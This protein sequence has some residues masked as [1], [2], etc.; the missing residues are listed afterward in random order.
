MKSL[1]NKKTNKKLAALTLASLL[2]FSLTACGEEGSKPGEPQKTVTE[3]GVQIIKVAHT[4]YYIPYDFADEN[5][6]SDGYEVAVLRAVD[7]LLPQY[8]FEFYPTTDD[9]LLIGVETG[10]YDVGTKGVWWTQARSETYV[11]PKQYIGASVIGI[12]TRS[13]DKDKYSSLEAFAASG[14]KLVPIAPQNA[15]YNIIQNFNA[16]HPD[17]Q[18]NLVEA[19][20]FTQSDA[21]QWLREGRYD[22]YVTIKTSFEASVLKE[23]GEYHDF[24]SELS[25]VDYEGIPTWPLFNINNQ[26]LADAYDEAIAQLIAD[27]TIEKI[28]NEY[29]GY[30]LFDYV[31]EGYKIGDDL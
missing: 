3:D 1:F 12:A 24:A 7:E 8:Q 10:K 29:F 5:G 18:I 16:K 22:A 25:Y 2:A 17:A 20:S 4:N 30:S 21:Y 31:P 13:S 19:D 9:D 6:N 15:Q 14:G 28:S 23:G 11:F 26:E 27:G